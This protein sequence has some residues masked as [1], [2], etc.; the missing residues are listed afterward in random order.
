MGDSLRPRPVNIHTAR[1]TSDLLIDL[2]I[3]GYIA[4]PLLEGQ[5]IERRKSSET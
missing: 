4:D 1:S 3:W 2:S 5:E